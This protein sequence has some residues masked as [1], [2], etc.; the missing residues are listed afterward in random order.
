M[1][2][3]GVGLISSG[4][5]VLLILLLDLGAQPGSGVLSLCPFPDLRG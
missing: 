2:L 4:H 5:W 3:I 1:G